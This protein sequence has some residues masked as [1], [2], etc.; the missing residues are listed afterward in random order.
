MTASRP[1]PY[2]PT[3]TKA[4]GHRARSEHPLL[5]GLDLSLHLCLHPLRATGR[6][7]RRLTAFALIVLAT[8]LTRWTGSRAVLHPLIRE[9]IRYAGLRLLPFVALLALVGGVVFVGQTVVLLRQFGAQ[10]M[11]GTI[12]AVALFQEMGPM[13][14]ALLVLLRVGTAT[15]VELATMRATG[16]IEALEALSIDP[17]HYLVV[18]RVVGMAL[19]VFCLTVYLILGTLLTGYVFCFLQQIPLSLNAYA[20]QL[21]SALR[22]ED[23]L[24]VMVKSA[25][26]GATLAVITCYQGLARPLRLEHVPEAATRAVTQSLIVFLITDLAI[27]SIRLLR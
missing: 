7:T 14:A 11:L 19:S 1:L 24:L 20:G 25:L 13:V 17:I 4:D 18:P 27:L 15:V 21:T 12:L 26:F 22:A 5:R 6:T 16:E 2:G 3:V 8:L 23:F 9:Q 10:D